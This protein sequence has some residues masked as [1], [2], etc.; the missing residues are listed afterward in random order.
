MCV[1]I[2][3]TLY[4]FTFFDFSVDFKF[5]TLYNHYKLFLRRIYMK[6]LGFL[7]YIKER[8]YIFLIIAILFIGS[9]ILL[10]NFSRQTPDN[11]ETQE[12]FIFDISLNNWGIWITALGGVLA[13]F[14]GIYQFDKS[15][16]LSQQEKGAEIAKLFSDELLNKC[17]IIGTVISKSS[18]GDL[19]DLK[20][21]NM[22]NLKRFDREEI[23]NLYENQ[24]FWNSYEDC[25]NNGDLQLTYLHLL[26]HRISTKSIKEII[27]KNSKEI[28]SIIEKIMSKKYSKRQL[29]DLKAK[30]L[31]HIEF[32]K[33]YLQKHSIDEYNNLYK[34]TY[35]DEEA[36]KLFVLD[37]QGLPF[38]FGSLVS[39]VLNELEYICMYISSQSAGTYYIYQSLHQIFLRTVKT[40]AATIGYYNKN[41]ADKYYTNIIH[42]YVEWQKI[43]KKDGEKEE[44][45]K[46]KAFKYLEP[47][48]RRV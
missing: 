41:Y 46:L 28:T 48:I 4:F 26:E 17:Y 12:I 47:K 23:S 35:T 38:R 2:C 27:Y 21:I 37:N 39:D 3:R 31:L 36:R 29:N 1:E 20:H 15:K 24:Q 42:V 14:W 9:S 18:L 34:R 22:N 45:N 44:K 13:L 32:K 25:F 10:F 43:R 11:F 33:F 30:G 6:H 16:N 7:N 19:L 40:L 5:K 8:W